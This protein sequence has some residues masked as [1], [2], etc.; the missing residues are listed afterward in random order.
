MNRMDADI[1]ISRC[2]RGYKLRCSLDKTGADIA[3]LEEETAG[4]LKG[5]AA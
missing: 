5:L 4:M 2:A 3:K 1:P